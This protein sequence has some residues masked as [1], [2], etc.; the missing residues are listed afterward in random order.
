MSSPANIV[1]HEFFRQWGGW[2]SWLAAPH[3]FAVDHPQAA[4]RFAQASSMRFYSRK[5]GVWIPA[6]VLHMVYN[7]VLLL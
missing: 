4:G 2:R 1:P 7:A 3:F 5:P 6:I